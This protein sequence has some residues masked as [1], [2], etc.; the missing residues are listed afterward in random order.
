M[1]T[2]SNSEEAVV[3]SRQQAKTR[4]GRCAEEVKLTRLL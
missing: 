1:A 3:G 2:L 4:Y